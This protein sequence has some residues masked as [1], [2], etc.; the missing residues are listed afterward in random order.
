[1]ECIAEALVT[2][3]KVK[4]AA[5]LTARGE[6]PHFMPRSISHCALERVRL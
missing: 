4:S 2:I 1:M 6:S 5:A 3:E